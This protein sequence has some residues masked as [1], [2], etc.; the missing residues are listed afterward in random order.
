LVV[1]VAINDLA[2]AVSAVAVVVAAAAAAAAAD[3][4]KV[5]DRRHV[6]VA[7]VVDVVGSERMKAIFQFKN[8]FE[9]LRLTALR[10]R[11]DLWVVLRR[12]NLRF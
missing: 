12:G 3:F 1:F 6:D 7:V 10:D 2:V 5:H 8:S 4:I 11:D 9:C